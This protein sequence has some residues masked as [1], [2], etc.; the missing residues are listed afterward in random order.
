MEQ[1][2]APTDRLDGP[3]IQAGVHSLPWTGA[4]A[5]VS[6]AGSLSREDLRTLSGQHAPH[7]SL[8]IVG[9]TSQGA[10]MTGTVKSKKV[11]DASGEWTDEMV[12]VLDGQEVT[13]AEFRRSFPDR[14]G[15]MPM[16]GNSAH[17][18]WPILSDAM[19]VHPLQ[20]QEAEADAARKGVPTQFETQY[21]R[22]IFR[23]REH[24]RQYIKK[25]GIIDRSSYT[26]Y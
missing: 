15:E 21:G 10:I 12:Y 18:G 16:L 5:Y 3:Q 7:A 11:L 6:V 4:R 13:E 14:S 23:N 24:R 17:R 22:P 2:D 25:Y 26:G 1:D 8:A 19:A 9:K 20:V